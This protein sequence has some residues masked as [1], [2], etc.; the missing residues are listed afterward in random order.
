[1]QTTHGNFD[2]QILGSGKQAVVFIN[3]CGET[4]RIW[5]QIFPVI[6]KGHTV[7]LF[8]RCGTG[9][10]GPAKVEQTGDLIV[11]DIHQLLST[12]ELSF[13]S[14]LVGHGYGSVLA[15]LYCRSF[16]DEVCGVVFVESI[17]P[18]AINKTPNST[19]KLRALTKSI[20]AVFNKLFTRFK[21][22]EQNYI[23]T[24]RLSLNDLCFPQ[25][26][27]AVVFGENKSA[28]ESHEQFEHRQAYQQQLQLLSPMA[29]SYACDESTCEPHITEPVMV[30]A[31]IYATI[32]DA[33]KAL[34]LPLKGKTG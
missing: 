34:A 28:L 31:A 12:L 27:L 32:K 30:L 6:A 8:N 15:D 24:T 29:R 13:P 18:Q 20:K 9:E 16:S 19:L 14:V 33:Q 10:V 17:A 26:P 5:D 7:I 4:H 23:N 1:V 3:D 22:N 11:N 25:I 21:I 2:Y